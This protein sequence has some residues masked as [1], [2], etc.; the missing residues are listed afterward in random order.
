MHKI[1]FSSTKKINIKKTNIKK[2][3]IN[4]TTKRNRQKIE[5]KVEKR[6]HV[7]IGFIVFLFAILCI[8]IFKIQIIHNEMSRRTPALRWPDSLLSGGVP[9]YR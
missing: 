8:Y 2:K 5:K 4:K 6:Y 7:L 9:E 1:P 3:P